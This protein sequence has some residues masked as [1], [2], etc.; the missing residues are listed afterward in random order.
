MTAIAH[1][2]PGTTGFTDE[3]HR[4]RDFLVRIN[5]AI[6]TTPGFLW[7]RWEWM[8][9]LPYL[10]A[11]ALHRIRIWEH[12]GRV[13][14]VVTYETELGSAYLLT[15]PEHADLLP[16]MLQ[17][18]LE[19]LTRGGEVRVLVG[20]TD[21]NLQRIAAAHGLTATAE[22]EANAVLDLAGD[23]SYRLPA[24]YRIA[25]LA[26]ERD[27][28][29]F[30][31]LLHRGFNNPGLPRANAEAIQERLT[32]VSGPHLNPELNMLVVAPDGD[33]AAYCGIW[34]EPGT[35]YALVEPV[36]T[37]PDHRRRGLGRAAVLEAARRCRDL[38]ARAAYVGSD[39]LFYYALG[40][41]PHSRGIWWKL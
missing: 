40:F 14:A 26:N 6:P 27:M 16:D 7:G 32:S 38:G 4:V 31:R 34:H 19:H 25:S 24:G 21:H 35:T 33:Y 12:N 22:A 30:D 10:D 18:A 17:Y 23:L 3:F 9:S 2:H 1:Q 8:F 5:H 39:Q 20:E 28:L 11:S 37:D 36:C 15:D 13:V 41:T 29:R